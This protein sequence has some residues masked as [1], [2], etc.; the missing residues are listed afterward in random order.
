MTSLN[1]PSQKQIE[2]C[3]LE[4]GQNYRIGY[5]LQKWVP[6]MDGGYW[7]EMVAGMTLEEHNIMFNHLEKTQVKTP[8][9]SILIEPLVSVRRTYVPE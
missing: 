1:T 3:S 6:K 7:E 8:F 5:T 2:K 4:W 9:R